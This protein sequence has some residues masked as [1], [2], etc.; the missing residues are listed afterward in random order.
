VDTIIAALPSDFPIGD[1]AIPPLGAHEVSTLEA[2]HPAA[3]LFFRAA[4]ELYQARSITTFAERAV[5]PQ[6]LA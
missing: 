3:S 1:G 2:A 6:G 4:G 5:G